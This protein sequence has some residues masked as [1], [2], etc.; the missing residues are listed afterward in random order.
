VLKLDT[1]IYTNII[2]RGLQGAGDRDDILQEVWQ[3][4]DRSQLNWSIAELAHGDIV[5][6]SGE[7]NQANT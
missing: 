4:L 3:T 2:Y 1:I 6:L 7:A 5:A